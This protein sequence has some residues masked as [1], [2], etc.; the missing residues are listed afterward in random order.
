MPEPTASE[1]CYTKEDIARPGFEPE[2]TVTGAA[3]FL[4]L[5]HCCFLHCAV[6]TVQVTVQL[7]GDTT[8]RKDYLLIAFLGA[9]ELESDHGFHLVGLSKFNRVTK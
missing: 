2:M 5:M 6:T 4:F 8:Y 9:E 7:N 1:S 3:C